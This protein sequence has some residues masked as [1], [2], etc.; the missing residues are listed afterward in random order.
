MSLA[1]HTSSSG[2]S[3]PGGTHCP[4]PLLPRACLEEEL[5]VQKAKH[6]LALTEPI[7]FP[8]HSCLWPEGTLTALVAPSQLVGSCKP[9]LGRTGHK[10]L[11]TPCW[12]AMASLPQTEPWREA[13]HSSQHLCSAVQRPRVGKKTTNEPNS[14]KQHDEQRRAAARNGVG[15][16][17][18]F[19]P[20]E[21]WSH[22]C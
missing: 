11:T 12:L 13:E 17:I 20:L 9:G 21:A 2:Q 3:Q 4:H 19:L 15:A 8:G 7:S 1:T 22:I 5:L 16:G 14:L 18:L 6:A 10:F